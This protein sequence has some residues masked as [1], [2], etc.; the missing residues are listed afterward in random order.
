[1]PT[2]IYGIRH[3]GPGSARSLL[4]ALETDPPDVLLVEAP[5]DVE[6][7]LALVSH[8]EMKPPVALFVCDAT[9]A[10]HSAFIPFAEY[11]P[12]WVAIRFAMQRGIPVRCMDLPYG[13]LLALE[14]KSEETAPPGGQDPGAKSAPAAEDP[15][16]FT[17]DPLRLLARAAGFDDTETWWDNLVEQQSNPASLFEGIAEAMG[18][19]RRT[20]RQDEQAST[21]SGEPRGDN[22]HSARRFEA[23]REA[24]MRK[25]LREA[26]RQFDTVA[27]VCG[28]WHAPALLAMPPASHDAAL[29]RGLPW[30]M[31]YVAWAPWTYGQLAT[32]SGYGAGVSSPAWYELLWKQSGRSGASSRETAILWTI[33]AARLLRGKDLDA[34]SASVI[35]SVRLA[36]ALGALRGLRAP[37]LRELTDAALATLTH[38]ETLPFRIVSEELIIGKR[39][40]SIPAEAPAT[41]LQRDFEAHLRRFRIK[42]TADL[43]RIELDL[44]EERGLEKSRFFHRVSL[45]DFDWCSLASTRSMG[46]FKEVWQHQWKPAVVVAMVEASV[47]GSSICD[48]AS[49]RVRDLAERRPELPALTALSERLLLAELPEATAN[50]LDRMARV[51]AMTGDLQALLEAIPPLTRIARYSNVRRT[52]QAVV[53]ELLRG[54]LER[55]CVGMVAGCS[56][57]APDTASEMRDAIAKVHSALKL[58][59]AEELNGAWYAALDSTACANVTP[60]LIAGALTRILLDEDRVSLQEATRRFGLALSLVGRDAASWIEGFLAGNALLL[61]TDDRL[62]G[63]LNR[64]LSSLKPEAFTE[65]LPL[66]RRTFSAYSATE[67]RQLGEKLAAIV[68]SP[69]SPAALLGASP[70]AGSRDVGDTAGLPLDEESLALALGLIHRILPGGTP[71][72]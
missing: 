19:L 37:G 13:H 39:M 42:P 8:A 64:W 59:Q 55:A 61:L 23:L 53:R 40:G 52:E 35:E 36:E 11:S 25:V 22:P 58:L 14:A 27:V 12:E 33:G 63:M 26:T 16:D 17:H 38:G 9:R 7:S 10:A 4:N 29:L 32:Q 15:E 43:T 18:E 31:V 50:V 57:L 34:S 60:P 41:P 30:M 56:Q 67:R 6:E 46:T 5:A 20:L 70:A 24:W 69:E 2:R 28:A 54:L 68:T 65:H 45:L 66:L 21:D 49:A 71:R 72:P 3:H 48:A 1:M 44:R 47:L 51:A 62:L